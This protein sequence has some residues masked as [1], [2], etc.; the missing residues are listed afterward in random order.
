MRVLHFLKIVCIGHKIHRNIHVFC[1]IKFKVNGWVL[2]SWIYF[3]ETIFKELGVLGPLNAYW[4]R[5]VIE[6]KAKEMV[7]VGPTIC[8]R[9]HE[10]FPIIVANK[11]GAVRLL[12]GYQFKSFQLFGHEVT[13]RILKFMIN[14]ESF[15]SLIALFALIWLNCSECE[16]TLQEKGWVKK[17]PSVRLRQ[18]KL[19]CSLKQKAQVLSLSEFLL[20][21]VARGSFRFFKTKVKA[22][23]SSLLYRILEKSQAV[24][25]VGVYPLTR[26]ILPII[27]VIAESQSCFQK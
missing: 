26:W 18:D 22:V 20:T 5:I 7:V 15:A 13:S 6:C 2:Q 3:N 25:H 24:T 8:R 23:I 12:P 17:T 10:L 1:I 11:R 19:V 9:L 21:T 16:I 27:R 4:N 14:A